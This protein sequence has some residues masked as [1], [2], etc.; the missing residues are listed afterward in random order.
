MPSLPAARK[1][2]SSDAIHHTYFL[3][4]L[5]ADAEIAEQSAPQFEAEQEAEAKGHSEPPSAA[6]EQ[7]RDE[8]MPPAGEQ[9]NDNAS[10]HAGD[11]E[12]EPT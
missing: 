7:D 2:N 10:E 8:E 5:E 4:V 11:G 9:V 6:A 1:L 3:V 12:D